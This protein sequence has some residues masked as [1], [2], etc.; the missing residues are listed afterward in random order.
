MFYRIVKNIASLIFNLLYRIEVIGK[1]KIPNNEKLIICGNHTHNFDVAIISI[2]FPNQIHWMG[3]KE[4]FKFKPLAF[5]L[6]KLGS[7]PVD[8]EKPG[9]S[10]IKNSMRILGDN[11]SLGIFPEGTRVKEFDI[12][13]AKPGVALISISTQAPI[14]PILIEGTYRPFSKIKVSIGDIFDFS[15]AY[16]KR[17]SKDEYQAYGEQVLYNIYNLKET[18]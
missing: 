8:R 2:L 3:K 5:I 15:E 4:L 14:L 13:N 7:F 17:P 18:K 9:L 11:K 10:A 12:K 16:G 6:E 1:E